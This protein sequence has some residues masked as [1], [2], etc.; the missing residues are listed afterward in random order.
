MRMVQVCANNFKTVRYFLDRN[1]YNECRTIGSC[2]WMLCKS[3]SQ[4]PLTCNTSDL[5][6][7]L[8]LHCQAS[9]IS[10]NL[11]KQRGDLSGVDFHMISTI[12]R[13]DES[14]GSLFDNMISSQTWLSDKSAFKAPMFAVLTEKHTRHLWTEKAAS[15]SSSRVSASPL[16]D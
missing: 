12:E 14:R 6:N 7:I 3:T 2:R 4:P 13:K 9:Q 8:C 10:P 15:N 5:S 16:W 1:D 11:P